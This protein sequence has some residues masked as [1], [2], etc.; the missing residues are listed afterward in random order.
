MIE[1]VVAQHALVDRTRNLLGNEPTLREVAMFGGRSLMVN[2]AMIV[3]VRKTGELLVRVDAERDAEL[4]RRPGATRGAMGPRRRA[5]AVGWIAVDADTVATDDSLSFW[6]GEA[7]AYN[8]TV[9][10][11]R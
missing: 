3:S 4:L 9:T 2:G 1:S 11:E 6:V 5:M 7:L 8:R 10:G